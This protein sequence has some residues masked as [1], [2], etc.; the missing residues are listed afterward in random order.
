MVAQ[1]FDLN[2]READLW[3]WAHPV[4][5]VSSI[6]DIQSYV[7]RLRDSVNKTKENKAKI[8]K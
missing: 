8:N 1:V 6:Q 4:Y 5:I 7:E 2:T 3:G